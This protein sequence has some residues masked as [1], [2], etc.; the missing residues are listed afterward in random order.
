R[1]GP[2]RDHPAGLGGFGGRL[3]LLR[4]HADQRDEAGWRS[5]QRRPNP[6]HPGSEGAAARSIEG[7]IDCSA[8]APSPPAGPDGARSISQN[9]ARSYPRRAQAARASSS[10]RL[11]SSRY[12][13]AISI[14]TYRLPSFS[15]ATP[16]VPLPLNGS[17]TSAPGE[18][19]Q[20]MIRSS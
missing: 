10:L 16:V 15:A 18:V 20:P 5:W 6:L 17:S 8:A 12:L 4:L 11:D 19:L 9:G 2:S 7:E 3:P 13:G 1:D 14:P